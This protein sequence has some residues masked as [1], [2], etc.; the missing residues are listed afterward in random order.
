V[1]HSNSGKETTL[2]NTTID[3]NGK[4]GNITDK[5]LSP[6]RRHKYPPDTKS[7]GIPEYQK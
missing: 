1:P 6:L 4:A 2:Y 5:T 3:T 7:L